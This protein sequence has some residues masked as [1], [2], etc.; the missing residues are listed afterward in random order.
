MFGPIRAA[1]TTT[2]TPATTTATFFEAMTEATT[3][4]TTTTT[5][6]TTSDLVTEVASNLVRAALDPAEPEFLDFEDVETV[7]A[8]NLSF[9]AAFNMTSP[10]LGKPVGDNGDWLVIAIPL[11]M[12]GISLLGLATLKIYE[13]LVKDTY[14]DTYE[15][16]N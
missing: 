2:A 9:A 15:C 12:F 4:T 13:W 10:A 11:V 1:T 7:A 14:Q 8:D 16:N 6:M 3:T 5:T